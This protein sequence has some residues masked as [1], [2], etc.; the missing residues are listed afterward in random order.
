MKE[1]VNKRNPVLPLEYHIP[2]SE[3]HVMPDGKLYIYGSYDDREDVFC[4]EKY[5]VVSTPD[6]EHWS[7][8]DESLTGDQIPWFN[9]PDAPKYPGIDWSHPTPF[10]RKMLEQ[11]ASDG[12]DMKEKFEQQEEGEKPALLFAPD[13]IEKDGK[14]NAKKRKGS[15]YSKI[16]GYSNQA[17]EH[18]QHT[19]KHYSCPGLSGI[20]KRHIP[21]G[22]KGE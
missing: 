7:I 9:D 19:G 1:F 16:Q 22:C 13:C 21:P 2:D 10:I 4:S 11:A 6:M 15:L 20:G 8:S 14:D 17:D 5:Y 3:G 18:I 12:E